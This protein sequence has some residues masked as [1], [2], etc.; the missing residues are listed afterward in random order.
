MQGIIVFASVMATLGLQILFESGRELVTKVL[1]FYI[2]VMYCDYCF[3]L[4]RT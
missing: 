4:G 3:N 1:H 2:G